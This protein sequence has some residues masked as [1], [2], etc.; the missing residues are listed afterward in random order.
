MSGQEAEVS[1]IILGDIPIEVIRKHIKNLHLSVYPPMGRVK[2][3]AP[4]RM[5]LETI[6][7]FLI[8]K[9]GWIRDQQQKFL[10]QPRETPREFLDKESHFYRGKRYLLK[11]I[12]HEAPPEIRLSHSTIEMKVR[13]GTSAE[14]MKTLLDEWY[15]L[16]L[17][18]EIPGIIE[19][20]ER[21]MGERVHQFG[22]K[23]MRT[24]WGTCNQKARRIWV[25]LELAKKPPEC[26]E[27]IVGH[28]MVHLIER[29]HGER[30]ISL[31]DRLLPKWRFYREELNRLP[32]R[33]EDWEY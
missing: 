33:H 6:R 24:R 29:G 2:V 4:L 15:R 11:I 22:V 12:T 3:A 8:S 10:N 7:V 28:E 13:Q 18:E 17:K 23:K 16:K 32:V 14:K 5:D 21:V 25:N 27:Y 31:M 26:L 20:W 30:F 1:E 19:K 9:L